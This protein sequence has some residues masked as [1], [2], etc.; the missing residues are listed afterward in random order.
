MV[1]ANI[2]VSLLAALIVETSEMLLKAVMVL[3][4]QISAGWELFKAGFENQQNPQLSYFLDQKALLSFPEYKRI[5]KTV[6]RFTS[7]FEQNAVK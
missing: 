6:C 1:S 7:Y 2:S 3:E 4:K 5:L